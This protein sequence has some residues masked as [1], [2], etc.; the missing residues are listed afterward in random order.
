MSIH[1]RYLLVISVL[2]SLAAS[3]GCSRSAPVSDVSVETSGVQMRDQEL[4]LADTDWPGWRGPN[5]D[6]V[7]IDQPIVTRW[8]ASSN[9]AWQADVPGRGHSSP[10]VVGQ[11]VFLTTA[12]EA[13]EQQLV[14]AYDRQ[15]G[16]SLWTT[17][18][19]EGNF[20]RQDSI[21]AKSSHANSTVVCDGKRIYASFLNDGHVFVTA[22]NVDGTIVWQ[23]DTGRFHSTYGY[24]P[25]PILHRSCVI[26]AADHEKGGYLAALDRDT[27]QLAWRTQRPALDSYSSPFICQVAG[28]PQLLICGCKRV[29][30]FDPATGRMNW[31]CPGTARLTCGTVVS[32]GTNVYAS[33]GYPERETICVRGDGSEEVLW[34][35]DINV[36]EPSL[37]L[38]G[39]HL[40]AVNDK[41]IAY[42]WT[43]RTGEL[44]WRERLRGPFSASPILCNGLILVSNL[45]GTTYVFEANPNGYQPVA[46]NQLGDDCYTSFAVSN[47]WLFTRVGVKEEDTRRERLYCIGQLAE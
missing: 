35:N 3:Y 12:I 5:S 18:V 29:A 24:A 44:Q 21:H 40:F 10:V 45:K 9:I 2:W 7:A 13:A 20:P 16:E 8:D 43:A 47:G 14:L 39:D 31:S 1:L 37:L 28:K 27:G 6:G 11:R 33:G 32:D 26:I 22:L 25:S 38:A 42:C 46:T 36:Y 34:R 15:S 23:T 4:W 41:G 17:P 19:H 30:S